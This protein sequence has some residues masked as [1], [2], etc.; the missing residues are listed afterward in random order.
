MKLKQAVKLSGM[1]QEAWAKSQG[2]SPEYASRMSKAGA[3]VINGIVYRETKYRVP[4][5]VEGET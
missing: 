3:I 2:T 5:I 1:T 4:V